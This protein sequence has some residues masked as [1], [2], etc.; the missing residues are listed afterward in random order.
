MFA[1]KG[2]LLFFVTVIQ[3]WWIAVWGIVYMLIEAVAGKSKWR[4]FGFYLGS[5]IF[6]YVILEYHPTLLEHF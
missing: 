3:L 4:E 2:E 1:S 5:M 6:V